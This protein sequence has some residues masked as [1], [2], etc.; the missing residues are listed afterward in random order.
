MASALTEARLREGSQQG[1]GSRSCAYGKQCITCV[2]MQPTV[3]S[4]MLLGRPPFS[5]WSS[6]FISQLTCPSDRTA[7]I[8]ATRTSGIRE[9]SQ[10]ADGRSRMVRLLRWR[11]SSLGVSS[12]SRSNESCDRPQR[13]FYSV[14]GISRRNSVARTPRC[15]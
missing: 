13:S 10:P 4:T 3:K 11:I 9:L 6:V 2:L 5:R 1:F 7:G 14:F 8:A 15:A 12:T